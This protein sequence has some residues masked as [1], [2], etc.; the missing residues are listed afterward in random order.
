MNRARYDYSTIDHLTSP[1]FILPSASRPYFTLPLLLHPPC[2]TLPPGGS[3]ARLCEPS[4][5]GAAR[6]RRQEVEG[7][8][9]KAE[10]RRQK[11]GGR[12]QKAEA[13]G[14]RQKAEGRR[15]KAEGRRQEAEGRRQKTEGRR[16][17]A[18]QRE[19]QGTPR[20]DSASTTLPDC[21]EFASRFSIFFPS[22]SSFLL[23]PSLL[24]L[25]SQLSP[26][27]SLRSAPSPEARKASLPT[28]PEG[29]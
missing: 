7:R 10:G 5:R 1:R 9:Q 21:H 29:G 16:Q 19:A 27:S 12:R 3:T 26:L 25:S 4:G 15:Q 13:E 22:P 24:F 14:R 11:A 17:K 2:F 6:E 8:R 23:H 28:L 20:R 18:E